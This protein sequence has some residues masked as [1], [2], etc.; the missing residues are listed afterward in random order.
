MPEPELQ[1]QREVLGELDLSELSP[2]ALAISERLMRSLSV[3]KRALGD[4]AN[5]S[6]CPNLKAIYDAAV[7]Y[8]PSNFTT[9]HTDFWTRRDAAL[10]E[11]Q[12]LGSDP[13]I[14]QAAEVMLQLVGWRNATANTLEGRD[15]L[16]GSA[17][18]IGHVSPWLYSGLS[19]GNYLWQAP[20]IQIAFPPFT[21]IESKEP[22]NAMRLNV[23]TAP[24]R[25]R[26]VDGGFTAQKIIPGLPWLD[27]TDKGWILDPRGSN[28]QLNGRTIVGATLKI[29][30]EV[31]N[32]KEEIF[33]D[34]FRAC[35]RKEESTAVATEDGVNWR[36]VHSP[37][38][39]GTFALGVVKFASASEVLQIGEFRSKAPGTVV[40]CSF[41]C[42]GQYAISSPELPKVIRPEADYCALLDDTSLDVYSTNAPTWATIAV[43]LRSDLT[44]PGKY[45]S[46]Q[47]V[48]A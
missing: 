40:F 6:N 16:L 8:T 28:D 27:L 4:R 7:N 39:N 13:D 47:V 10:D 25:T 34:D 44:D 18:E 45:L 35:V 14:R 37:E 3:L 33:F 32:K 19:R 12:H 31:I 46:E 22:V 21:E 23:V 20:W 15:L 2:A 1:F 26:R 17:K 29:P 41:S 5:T 9:A 30:S 43:A 11:L 38:L 48:V 42:T 24:G 36:I